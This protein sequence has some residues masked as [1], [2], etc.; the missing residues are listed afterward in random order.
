[1]EIN[2]ANNLLYGAT[3]YSSPLMGNLT[4]I[5][6]T[7]GVIVLDLTTK[8]ISSKFSSHLALENNIITILCKWINVRYQL[9]IWLL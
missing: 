1:M 7:S 8:S 2:I 3:S 9:I 4:V 6:L 5:E